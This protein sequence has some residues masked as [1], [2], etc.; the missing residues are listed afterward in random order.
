MEKKFQ[1]K[2]IEEGLKFVSF[3]FSRKIGLSGNTVQLG[4]LS[5]PQVSN[6]SNVHLGDLIRDPWS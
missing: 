6:G 3:F 5:F 1:E 4:L 2:K